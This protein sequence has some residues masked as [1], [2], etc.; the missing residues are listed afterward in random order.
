[1]N[2]ENYGTQSSKIAQAHRPAQIDSSSRPVHDG[3]NPG[4]GTTFSLG[5]STVPFS[6]S[7]AVGLSVKL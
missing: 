2:A 3:G 1:M 6:K 5:I 7:S 4:S